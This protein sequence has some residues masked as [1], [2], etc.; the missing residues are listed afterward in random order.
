MADLNAIRM[1][2]DERVAGDNTLAILLDKVRKSTATYMEAE[3]FAMRIGTIIADAIELFGDGVLNW[4]TTKDMCLTV[5]EYDFDVVSEYCTMVQADLNAK[6]LVRVKPLKSSF[7]KVNALGIAN[8]K[9]DGW[10]IGEQIKNY[11]MHE[12]D[13]YQKANMDYQKASGLN[14]QITR[15]MQGE[16]CSFCKGLVYSGAYGGA[17][18]PKNIFAR[19]RSCDCSIIYSPRAGKYQDV[20]SKKEA[21]SYY[22]AVREQRKELADRN[23]LTMSEVEK[24]RKLR[25]K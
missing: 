7:D 18:M 25:N 14:P 11:S 16:T 2:I 12:V 19:H 15:T 22:E 24:R 9:Q 5:L 3:R 4:E 17:G 21:T 13:N 23:Y 10:Q 8:N 6:Y 1:Y 20:W